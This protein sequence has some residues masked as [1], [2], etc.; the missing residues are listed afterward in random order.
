M[1]ALRIPQTV[2]KS[3]SHFTLRVFLIIVINA[4]IIVTSTWAQDTWHVDSSKSS[5]RIF[6]GSR[7]DPYSANP[8]IAEVSGRVSLDLANPAVV[9][10]SMY[11]AGS[12][13]DGLATSREAE[14]KIMFKSKQVAVEKNSGVL[15]VT[16]DLVVTHVVRPIVSAEPN[17]AYSG[18]VYGDPEIRT[19][20]HL[21]MLVFPAPELAALGAHKTE[22][23]SILPSVI[24]G[25][26]SFPELLP[27]VL[28]TNW[29]AVVQHEECTSTTGFPG[30]D[31]SG[32]KCTGTALSTSNQMIAPANIGGEDYSG[33]Q[34]VPR[35][36][37]QVT[38][39]F[40]LALVRQ[41]NSPQAKS[42]TTLRA[43][44]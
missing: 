24:V 20:H 44:R 22:T 1:K 13:P 12:S 34:L 19:A 15:N 18:P 42:V 9:D 37:N 32:P 3:K 28:A 6:L 8:G 39:Q 16:G 11:P 29:P 21:V 4:V 33:I 30:E 10:L 7:T 2:A 43:A 35:A 36:G 26:E 27:V 38:F 5:A 23:V 17:E 40:D 41:S 14:T 31:Y 25:Y